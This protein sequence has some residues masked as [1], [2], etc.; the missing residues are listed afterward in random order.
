MQENIIVSLVL[1]IFVIFLAIRKPKV[2]LA[3]II[4]ITAAYVLA[5]LFEKL[6]KVAFF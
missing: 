3:I 1:G 6:S 2:L 5:W 4:V